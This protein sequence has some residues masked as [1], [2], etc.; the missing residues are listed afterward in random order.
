MIR[1][2]EV[3][4]HAL[5]QPDPRSEQHT[6]LGSG[7][8]GDLSV[9]AIVDGLELVTRSS[10]SC[11]AVKSVARRFVPTPPVRPGFCFSGVVSSN[12]ERPEVLYEN[13]SCSLSADAQLNLLRLAE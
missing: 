6:Q 8:K 3:I 11:R 10:R 4:L 1:W 9:Y 7:Q 12:C 5:L 13:L 2:I